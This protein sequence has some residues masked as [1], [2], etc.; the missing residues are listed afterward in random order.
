MFLSCC[1]YR[2]APGTTVP[3][4]ACLI[5]DSLESQDLAKPFSF[6]VCRKVKSSAANAGHIEV[7]LTPP[8][9]DTTPMQR[10]SLSLLN[11]AQQ[12][13]DWQPYRLYCLKDLSCLL[14]LV[15]TLNTAG[16]LTTAIN[17]N[18]RVWMNAMTDAKDDEEMAI[19]SSE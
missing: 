10:P 2:S 6:L 7:F 19:Y 12:P 11:I 3:P 13:T 9:K 5:K 4:S 1:S 17:A 18:Q 16:Q 8:F 14:Q 15:Q